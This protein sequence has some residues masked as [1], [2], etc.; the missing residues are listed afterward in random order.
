M[1]NLEQLEKDLA[2][3]VS[4]ALDASLP[5]P[6]QLRLHEIEQ[7]KL[8]FSPRKQNWWLW[9]FLLLGLS[10]LASAYL[11]IATQKEEVLEPSIRERGIVEE[12]RIDRQTFE[13]ERVNKSPFIYQH[14]VISDD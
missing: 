1:D 13:N 9:V 2:L 8:F 14:E 10:G 5:V 11:L 3:P 4:R 12:D 7:E 6:D